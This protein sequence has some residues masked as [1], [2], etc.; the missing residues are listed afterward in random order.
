MTD[1]E[2]RFCRVVFEHADKLSSEF[3]QIFWPWFD[4]VNLR[5]E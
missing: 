2:E 1:F 5:D 3:W 4:S